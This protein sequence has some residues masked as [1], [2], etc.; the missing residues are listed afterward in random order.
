[1]EKSV[2]LFCVAQKIFGS[3]DQNYMNAN[4]ESI[5]KLLYNNLS[6]PK[7]EWAD[8]K[9][10]QISSSVEDIDRAGKLLSHMIS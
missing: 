1:M 7:I 10:V 2:N 8:S 9:I 4:F 6:S 3:S 5:K